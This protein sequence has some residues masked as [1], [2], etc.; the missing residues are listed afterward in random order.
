VSKNLLTSRLLSRSGVRHGFT[1][2]RLGDVLH[3]LSGWEKET[4]LPA[5][6]LVRLEQVHGTDVLIVDGPVGQLPPG[7]ERRF[8]AAVTTRNDV[9]L[10]VRTADC[11]P[12]LLF[13][14][15]VVAATHAGW[16][17]TLDGV[18]KNTVEAMVQLHGCRADSILAVLGPCIR[19]CCYRVDRD[20]WEPFTRSFRRDAVVVRDED[21]YVDLIVANRAWL[22]RSGVL[23][24]HID[25]V[26]GCTHCNAEQFFS[27]RREGSTGRQL[28]F[29]T[30]A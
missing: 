4:G 8:D 21:R 15:G 29:I 1:T 20:V 25:T 10:S 23:P 24:K 16:R 9:I 7:E 30:L 22:L 11:V 13:A 17:G 2:R 14:P 26:G 27:H 19:S 5:E 12:V 3:D 28:A 6:S 18:L